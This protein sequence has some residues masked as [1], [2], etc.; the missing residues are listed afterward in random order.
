MSMT[1]KKN[2]TLMLLSFILF[3]M[4]RL[5]KVNMNQWMSQPQIRNKK[6]NE[7]TIPGTHD[8]ASYS[9]NGKLIE[10]KINLEYFIIFI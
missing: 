6:L 1:A 3:S 9:I 4:V 2:L 8:T 10:S 5:E 7:I